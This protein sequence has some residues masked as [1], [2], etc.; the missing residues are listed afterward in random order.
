MKAMILAAGLGTRLKPFTD[1]HPK[2]LAQVNG[3]TLLA[4]NIQYLHNVGVSEIIVNVHHFADQIIDFIQTNTFPGVHID[5][6]DERDEVLETGGGLKKA[7]WFFGD[8][9]PFFLMNADILTTLDLADMLQVHQLHKPIAT[10]AVS[11]RESSR[12]FLFNDANQLCGWQHTQLGEQRIPKPDQSLKPLSFSGIHIIEPAIFQW[13][14]REGKFSMVDVYLDICASQ[15][16]LAYNHTGIPVLDVGSPERLS[17]AE[18][19][20]P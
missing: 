6:S 4:R 1:A 14:S 9:Q 15:T 3:K 7:A 11:E 10:I 18:K 16:I 20:F 19:L 12:A 17:I 8:H 2:A 13:M 5:I